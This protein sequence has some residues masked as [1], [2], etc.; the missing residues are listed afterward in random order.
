MMRRV[1]TAVE[2]AAVAAEAGL[3]PDETSFMA[4][5]QKEPHVVPNSVPVYCIS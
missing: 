4:H 1:R 3:E 2:E 5:L